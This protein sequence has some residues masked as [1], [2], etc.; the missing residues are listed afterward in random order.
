VVR[1]G[2]PDLLTSGV[3]SIGGHLVLGIGQ[4]RNL[5]AGRVAAGGPAGR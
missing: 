3:V 4:G 1:I 2:F 5:P